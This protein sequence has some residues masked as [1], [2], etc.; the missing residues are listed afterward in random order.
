M[1][2]RLLTRAGGK[3]DHAAMLEQVGHAAVGTEVAAAL[4]EGVAHLAT[5]R[6]RLSVRH[7]TNTATPPGA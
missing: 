7:S 1:H 5:V 2:E 3:T 4:A 6:L